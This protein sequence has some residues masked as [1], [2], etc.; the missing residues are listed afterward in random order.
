MSFEVMKEAG[1]YIVTGELRYG[2]KYEVIFNDSDLA[3][4]FLKSL[5]LDGDY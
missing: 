1:K 2:Y 5:T 3:L 4:Q